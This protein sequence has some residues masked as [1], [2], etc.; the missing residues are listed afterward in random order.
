MEAAKTWLYPTN[1]PMRDYQFTISEQCL[2]ANTLVALPQILFMAPT[3]P[4]VAQ[5][6]E[7]CQKITGISHDVMDE[8]TGS[9]S[10][11]LRR[12]SW[13]NKRIFFLTPQ[14]Q[15]CPAS[16]IVLVV[17]D[18]AHRATGNHAYCEVIKQLRKT[19]TDFRI[20]ALT[21]TPGADAQIVQ[22][23][24]ENLHIS[25]IELRTEES[26]D[27]APFTHKRN[28]ECIT[29]KPSEEMRA[30]MD[31]FSRIVS[32][33]LG[34]L[35][36][37]K[38]FF[39][40]DP[41][42]VGRY[43]LMMARDRLRGR[44]FSPKQKFRMDEDFSI[45]MVMC[46]AM[47][48]LQKL[49][50]RLFLLKLENFISESNQDSRMSPARAEF[51]QNREFKEMMSNMRIM[52]TQPN[53]VS[54]PKIGRLVELV[55][56]HLTNNGDKVDGVSDTRIMI[57]SQFRDSV[58][59]IV[60]VLVK[61]RPLVRPAFFIGQSSGKKGSMKGQKQKEQLDI[62][63]RFQSGEVNTVVATS[64]GEEGLD[65]GEVDLIICYDTQNSPI[66]MLQRMGRTGRK[67]EGRA[68]L[69]LAEGKEEDSY[70]RSQAQYKA[71][72]KAIAQDK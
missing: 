47:E 53:F 70:R 57:F 48:H 64:I 13:M 63:Q 11:E 39:E 72:Q 5:Q 32:P 65:I 3:K 2:F 30:L 22:S 51:I 15:T 19:T 35:V 46:D 56:N 49:G 37:D 58:E 59:E 14:N 69:L 21:A 33:Y 20:M 6:I 23:V 54:H 24:L 62:I 60:D 7:A 16:K 8:M 1:Q 9:S 34:R 17:V 28:Q 29:V 55:L 4:L 68:V 40:K 71:I 52:L 38:V 12:L 31:L 61:H 42:K 18:E 50:I 41:R 26:P 45:C 44:N 10:P 67:R 27:I 66:R 36:N 43:Q 25:R